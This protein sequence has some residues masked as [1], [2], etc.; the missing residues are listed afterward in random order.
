MGRMISWSPLNL[1]A[2]TGIGHRVVPH[3]VM[4]CIDLLRFFLYGTPN[5]SRVD[6]K[7]ELEHE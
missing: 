6:F 3:K 5:S 7:A 1:G 2:F 4:M